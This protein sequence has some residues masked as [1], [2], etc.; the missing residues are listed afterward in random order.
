MIYKKYDKLIIINLIDE[1]GSISFD[2]LSK[3]LEERPANVIYCELAGKL[4]GIIS[5]GDI[6]FAGYEGKKAVSI[7]RKFTSVKLNE[8]MKVRQIFEEKK[9]INAVPVIDESGRLL[10]DYTRWDDLLVLEYLNLFDEHTYLANRGGVIIS[11]LSNL[12]NFLMKSKALWK[13]GN[14]NLSS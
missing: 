11:R 13:N 2:E 14:Q 8:Y 10:G 9:K 6:A 12:A 5:T 3:V 4:Y 7:N 1:A